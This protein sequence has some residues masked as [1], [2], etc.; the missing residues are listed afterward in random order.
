MAYDFS[1]SFSAFRFPKL[2]EMPVITMETN[3]VTYVDEHRAQHD[4]NQD[5]VRVVDKNRCQLVEKHGADVVVQLLLAV[6]RL[7]LLLFPQEGVHLVR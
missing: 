7:V 4:G 6:H 2:A 5:V 3:V 1:E